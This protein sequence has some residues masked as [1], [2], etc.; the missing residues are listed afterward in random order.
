MNLVLIMRDRD[1]NVHCGRMVGWNEKSGIIRDWE[2][3]FRTL[4][5]V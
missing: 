1:K 3:V 2:S 5:S 4:E